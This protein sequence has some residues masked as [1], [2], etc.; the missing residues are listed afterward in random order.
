M[1]CAY[2]EIEDAERS[3]QPDQRDIIRTLVVRFPFIFGAR[4][5]IYYIRYTCLFRPPHSIPIIFIR[6]VLNAIELWL[7]CVVDIVELLYL[8]F[9]VPIYT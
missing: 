4:N 1:E 2:S 8:N 3:G 9:Y 7:L 6:N 5:K